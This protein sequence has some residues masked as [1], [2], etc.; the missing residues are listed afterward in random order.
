MGGRIA[1][2]IN[3]DKAVEVIIW[4]ADQKPD[5]DIYHVAKVLFYADKMHINRYARPILG[6]TYISMDYGPVPSGVR[7]LITKNSWL[8]PD[9]LQIIEDSL[10]IEQSPYPRLTA[11]RK[12]NMDFFS[13]TDI[14]CLQ[15]SL[16]KYGNKSF[17]ELKNL[18]HAE[19][20]WF[21]TDITQPI[22][23][24]LMVDEDNPNRDEIIEEMSQTSVYVQV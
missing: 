19:R 6:D 4:L 18:T 9:Y 10:K 7:D 1:Y 15:E 20:Y 11:L 23:Y 22:N 5:I 16:G 13:G 2:R 3:Y 14:E 24:V 21:E 17:D 12:P 8:N